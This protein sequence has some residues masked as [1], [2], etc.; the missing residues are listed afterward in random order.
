MRI[1]IAYTT[2]KRFPY[3][4]VQVF[5]PSSPH[6]PTSRSSRDTISLTNSTGGGGGGTWPPANFSIWPVTRATALVYCSLL[7]L[8]LLPCG[9][10]RAKVCA[11]D[12]CPRLFPVVFGC[13]AGLWLHFV[14]CIWWTCDWGP[15]DGEGV[16]GAIWFVTWAVVTAAWYC[17]HSPGGGGGGQNA[18]R[19]E[20]T[21]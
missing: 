2:V 16:R 13:L 11:R 21:V 17:F 14:P 10:R 19:K 4:T 20:E 1:I 18:Q 3:I 15:F 12:T 6:R 5:R 7:P 8:L 9:R